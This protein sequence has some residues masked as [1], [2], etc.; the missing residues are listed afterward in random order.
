MITIVFGMSMI[1]FIDTRKCFDMS[2]EVSR[3]LL[4]SRNWLREIRR[5]GERFQATF[6]DE[7][8]KYGSFK[9]VTTV[10]I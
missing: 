4:E 6:E 10:I 7:I 1:V 3:F 9:I 2:E 5:V 8:I